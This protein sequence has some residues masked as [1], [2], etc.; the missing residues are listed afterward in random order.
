[1]KNL[2]KTTRF[3]LL[4]LTIALF[5]A[6]IAGAASAIGN[7]RP[8]TAIDQSLVY[9]CT[10][11]SVIGITP[12]EKVK[13]A[14]YQILNEKGSVV[15]SGT[16]TSTKT[17]YISIYRLGGGVSTLLINGVLVRQFLVN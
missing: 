13:G 16:I 15:Y 4:I 8:L 9:D 6:N 1:M 3:A 7:A 12:S 17:F 11:G 10:E 14:Q 2:I 5:T